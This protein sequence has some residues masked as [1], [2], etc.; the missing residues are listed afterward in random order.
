M[1]Y[2]PVKI[3]LKSYFFLFSTVPRIVINKIFQTMYDFVRVKAQY[4]RSIIQGP[5]LITVRCT[6]VTNYL[7]LL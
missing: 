5:A 1:G 4:Q 6:T 3:C 2:R 7:L